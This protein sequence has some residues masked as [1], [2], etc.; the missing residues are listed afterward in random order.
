MPVQTTPAGGCDRLPSEPH[1]A[2]AHVADHVDHLPR[3]ID[4][5]DL[6]GLVAGPHAVVVGAVL[7][8]A[9]VGRGRPERADAGDHRLAARAAVV[10]AARLVGFLDTGRR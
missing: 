7:D 2:A 8:R 1:A 10:A 9:A 5:G 6:Q 3:T 4:A